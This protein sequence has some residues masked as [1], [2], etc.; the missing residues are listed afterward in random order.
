MPD[1]Y[2]D[3]AIKR[4]AILERLKSGQR[5]EYGKELRKLER[6]IRQTIGTLDENVSELSV[7]RLNQLLRLIRN[8]AQKVFES[9][10]K[11]LAKNEADIAQVTM[12]QEKIDLQETVTPRPVIATIGKKKLLKQVLARPLSTSGTLLQPWVKDFTDN[13]VTRIDNA[14]RKGWTEGSTNTQII[15]SIVG[16]KSNNYRDGVLATTRRNAATVVNTSVQHVAS[17]ARM[18]TWVEN[19]DLVKG[20]E[21]LS[22]LDSKTSKQCRSLDG[23]VFKIGKG[24]V[25]PIHPNCRSTT[26]PVLDDEYSF[27]D[28][29]STRASVNGPVSA[30]TTYY[31]WL[32]TQSAKTQNE[33]LGV[34]RAKL[35]RDGGLS[36]EEF[37]KLQLN[38]NFQPLTLEQMR[39]MEPEAFERAGL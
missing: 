31:G 25:P 12:Q 5:A 24:P 30:D 36:S 37:A 39:R 20:Y 6:L 28:Q 15:Q 32:G 34:E 9:A 21:W 11:N 27:L 26:T 14:V 4:Q 22:T 23:Q 35:F 8:D 29:D 2:L 16:T 1:S 33:V 7:T 19:S 18:D 17:A 3:L 13:E 38:K 10:N